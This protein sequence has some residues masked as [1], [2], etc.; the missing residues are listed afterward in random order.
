MNVSGQKRL[1]LSRREV[2]SWV[3]DAITTGAFSSSLFFFSVTMTAVA[4]QAAPRQEAMTAAVAAVADPF[5]LAYIK[6]RIRAA[7]FGVNPPGEAVKFFGTAFCQR[8]AN[9]S[10]FSPM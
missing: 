7:S 2:R 5:N 9:S 4:V 8:K 3:A 6:A 10:A 1:H